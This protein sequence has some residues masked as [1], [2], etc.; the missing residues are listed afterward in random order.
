MM[1]LRKGLIPDHVD[2]WPPEYQELFDDQASYMEMIG[3]VERSEAERRAEKNMREWFK[4]YQDH[5]PTIRNS[6]NR[7]D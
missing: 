3:G 1:N 2:D 5:F 4:E 6:G 7:P